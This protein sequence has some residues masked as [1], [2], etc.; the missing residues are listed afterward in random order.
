M[1]IQ[2]RGW[3]LVE[4]QTGDNV[5]K[6]IS[7]E[8]SSLRYD[9]LL[10]VS[11]SPTFCFFTQHNSVTTAALNLLDIIKAT[12][13]MHTTQTTNKR[14]QRTMYQCNMLL[15]YILSKEMLIQLTFRGDCGIKIIET[16][17]HQEGVWTCRS[18]NLDLRS[19]YKVSTTI[20]IKRMSA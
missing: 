20:F 5:K 10:Q 12:H 18:I 8:R 2:R 4:I 6:I 17:L 16:G 13:T 1:F 14:V 3:K 19:I 15:I 7:F 11:I 9:V